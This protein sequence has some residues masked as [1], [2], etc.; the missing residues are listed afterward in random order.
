MVIP[1]TGTFM[2]CYQ[3]CKRQLWLMSRQI[4]P[5]QSNPY[6][7]IGRLIDNE[8]YSR[9]RKKIHFDNVVIDVIKKDNEDLLVGEIKKSSSAQKSAEMQLAFYLYKLK[10]KG[11]NAKG[12][13]RFPEEKKR[14]EISLTPETEEELEKAFC[15]IRKIISRPQAPPPKKIKYCKNCG[16][17]EFCWS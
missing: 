8:S 14:V 11:V 5:D 13:L 10:E 2:Q 9:E 3:I 17:R 16:Y 15:E 1:I 7:E 4:V 12:E 6:I